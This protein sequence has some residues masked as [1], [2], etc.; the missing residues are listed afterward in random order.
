MA[1]VNTILANFS[2]C[3]ILTNPEKLARP[4]RKHMRYAQA[5]PTAVSRQP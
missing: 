3:L 5:T 4:K 1:P 2:G